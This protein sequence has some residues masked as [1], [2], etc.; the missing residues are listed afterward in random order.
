MGSEIHRHMKN[1][2][3]I[4]EIVNPDD[5]DQGNGTKFLNYCLVIGPGQIVLL[6]MLSPRFDNL[7]PRDPIAVFE[8]P[9]HL[10]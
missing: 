5:P 10:R 9:S 1:D 2:V 7:K 4:W 8:N 3:R 6:E